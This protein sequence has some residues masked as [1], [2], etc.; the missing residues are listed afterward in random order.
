MVGESAN[1]HAYNLED[2][3]ISAAVTETG[4]EQLLIDLDVDPVFGVASC[5]AIFDKS[6]QRWRLITTTNPRFADGSRLDWK[7]VTPAIRPASKSR[8]ASWTDKL[9]RSQHVENF[10]YAIDWTKTSLGPLE[11]WPVSL[12]TLVNVVFSDSRAAILYWGPELCAI[13]NEVVT[14]SA[15]GRLHKG[16]DFM[17]LPFTQVWPELSQEFDSMFKSVRSTGVGIH[18]LI[19]NLFPEQDG[20]LEETYWSG[21]FIP[22]RG[23]TG[24]IEG[25]WNAGTEIT[26]Q[27]MRERRLKTLSAI[28]EPLDVSSVSVWG[29]VFRALATNERDVPMAFAY[30]VSEEN[31]TDVCRL[32]L[33]QSIGLPANGHALVPQRA[34]M[35]EGSSGFMPYYR[36]AKASNRAIVLRSTEGTLPDN[37]LAGFLWRGFGEPSRVLA[38]CPIS[39]G[40]RLLGMMVVGLN[41]RRPWNADY[42]GF[43]FTLHS[44]VSATVSTALDHEQAR[45]RAFRLTRQLEESE[46]Q[47]RDLAEYAPVGMLRLAPSG[48]IIWANDQFY[49][50]T[51]HERGEENHYGLSFVDI[52][53]EEDQAA[54]ATSWAVLVDDR[55]DVN[56]NLRLN[57]RWTPPAVPGE[58]EPQPENVWIL[59][60]AYPVVQ[61]GVV[62]SVAAAVTDISQYKWAEAV[63]ERSAKAAQEAKRL[64]ENFVCLFAPT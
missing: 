14:T 21:G 45:Q 49:D 20:Q 41:P 1:G 52:V 54:S 24:E 22:V 53:A 12:Q 47:I 46:R 17:G 23:E 7:Q 30:S 32:E 29:H 51:G 64:Q 59:A 61:D 44:Q 9:P 28:A 43:I 15:I 13:P 2:L 19:T 35:F 48:N 34:N 3:A 63:Q 62:K 57:K 4:Q 10:K 60:R 38:I 55:K 18:A 33:Q 39:S 31:S 27:T 25:F 50:L 37:L 58:G 40:E 26:M 36:K 56:I 42:E 5:R 6:K 11:N 8:S 16:A